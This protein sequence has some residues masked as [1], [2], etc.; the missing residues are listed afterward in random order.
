MSRRLK[1]AG[2]TL[3]GAL[4]LVAVAALWVYRASQRVP[5]FYRQALAAPPESL[6][7]ASDDMLRQV[8]ALASRVQR[9]GDWEALFTAEQING[10]LAVDLVENH[11]RSLPAGVSEPRVAISPQGMSLA[12]RWD[13][14]QITTVLSLNVTVYVSEPNVLAVRLRRARAGNLPIPLDRVLDDVSH[15]TS[16]MDVVV[17]WLKIDGDPVALITIPPPEGEQD[18]LVWIESLELQEGAIYLSGR[19]LPQGE[20]PTHMLPDVQTADEDQSAVNSQRQ[21]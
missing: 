18:T 9:A 15:A 19:T 14:G 21:R 8:T 10:W 17:R 7:E 2:W 12:C 3:G 4:L 11:A 5:D 20:T 13:N 16:Q 6:D 1:I